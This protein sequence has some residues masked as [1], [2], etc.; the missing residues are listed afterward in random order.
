MA[1]LGL[2]LR[3]IQINGVLTRESKI[4]AVM[5]KDHVIAITKIDIIVTAIMI[6]I[7]LDICINYISYTKW[8]NDRCKLKCISDCDETL[9]I[10]TKYICLKKKSDPFIF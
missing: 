10:T 3:K 5:V 2:C 6:R 4:C 8:N 7:I 1:L 9:I